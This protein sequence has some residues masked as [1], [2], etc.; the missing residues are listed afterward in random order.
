M[1]RS[2]VN[3]AFYDNWCKQIFGS[4]AVPDATGTN[5]YYGGL[6]IADGLT[7]FINGREDPWKKVSMETPT[8]K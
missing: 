8:A 6:D 5:K 1:R 2:R 3:E 7:I 4:S